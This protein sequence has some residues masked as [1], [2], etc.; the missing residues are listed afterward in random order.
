MYPTTGPSTI[1][2]DN[3]I[4]AI[5]AIMRLLIKEKKKKEQKN[6]S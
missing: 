5:L 6:L 4:S 1:A 3:P 2:I